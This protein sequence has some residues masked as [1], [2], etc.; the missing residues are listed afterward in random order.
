MAGGPRNRRQLRSVRPYPRPRN[1]D[2]RYKAYADEPTAGEVYIDNGEEIE[3]LAVESLL[4][5]L[6]VTPPINQQPF[7]L[8]FVME[9]SSVAAILDRIAQEVKA[10][11]VPVTGELSDTRIYEMASGAAADGRPLIVLYFSDFDPSGHQMR[12]CVE[13][14]LHAL[15]TKEFPNLQYRVIPVALTFEQA[16]RLNLPSTLLKTSERR[17]DRWRERMGRE[18]TEIDALISLHPGELERI[19]REA[20]EPFF[21]FTLIDAAGT[22]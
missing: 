10:D 17:A 14:K 12:I 18:Q 8:A 19:T 13:W 2:A 21:D 7:R 15:T 3:L 16:E 1:E 6:I 5:Q 4:P 20:L 11:L 9:K 22:L